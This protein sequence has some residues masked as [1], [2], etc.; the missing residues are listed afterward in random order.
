MRNRLLARKRPSP[1]LTGQEASWCAGV[2]HAIGS[3]NFLF[4]ATQ[5]PHCTPKQIYDYFNVAASTALAHSKKVRERL[6]ISPYSPEWVR[7][8]MLDDSPLVSMLEVN[9]FTQDIRLLPLQIQVEAC[10]RGLIPYV[11]ALRD[12]VRAK[13]KEED[14]GKQEDNGKG[15]AG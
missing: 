5:T 7:P 15:V 11:P 10:S 1:L 8:S 6:S 12:Q 9:G 3:A 2:V 13:A 4:D 14:N